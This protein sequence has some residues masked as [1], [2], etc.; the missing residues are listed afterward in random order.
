MIQSNWQ[1][2]SYLQKSQSI[3]IAGKLGISWE[4]LLEEYLKKCTNWETSLRA[5]MAVRR[6][7]QLHKEK[8]EAI[9]LRVFGDA[10][11]TRTGAVIYFVIVTA[12]AQLSK[13][14]LT[15]QIPELVAMHNLCQNVKL[16]LEPRGKNYSKNLWMD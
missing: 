2:P 12:K 11:I 1:H 6:V 15:I 7:F 9:D 3:E 13:K 8:V 14:D 4:L 16:A 5:T 10:S